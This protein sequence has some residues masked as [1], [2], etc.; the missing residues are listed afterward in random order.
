MSNCRETI[1]NTC[2]VKTYAECAEY[3]TPP[4]TFSGLYES[5]CVSVEE[6]ITDTY[7]ILGGIKEELDLSGIA[8]DCI[9]LPEPLTA[10][11]LLAV[12]Y[13]KLC[14]LET[15]VAEQLATIET[16]Q[17]QIAALQN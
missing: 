14:V 7:S 15:K 16:M 8:E 13:T 2:G 1:K 10:A 6:A 4:P 12:A 17:A 9:I 5:S 11:S 3:Q